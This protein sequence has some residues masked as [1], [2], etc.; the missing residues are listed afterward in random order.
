[1]SDQ[2]IGLHRGGP[3]ETIL[4]DEPLA[5][6]R[7]LDAAA[8]LDPGPRREALHAVAAGHPRSLLAWSA[9]GDDTDDTVEAYAYYRVGYHRGLDEL[10]RSG[11]RGSGYVRWSNP[12]NRGFLRALHGLSRCAASIG[13]HDEAQRCELFLRQLDPSWPPP[14]VA[15][16]E[17]PA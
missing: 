1:M 2:P 16:G 12:S 17:T 3:P 14:D 15:E 11:W 8:D 6:H 9:L 4:D 7:S 10:R 13:E 5:V